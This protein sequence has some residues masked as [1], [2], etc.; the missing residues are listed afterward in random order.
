MHAEII[1]SIGEVGNIIRK[2]FAAQIS[3]IQKQLHS[4]SLLLKQ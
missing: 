1:K 3:T 2:W 4:V